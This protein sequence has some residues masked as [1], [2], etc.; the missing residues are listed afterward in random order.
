MG[1]GDG[2]NVLLPSHGYDDVVLERLSH[3]QD[4]VVLDRLPS[5][6]DVVLL[7]SMHYG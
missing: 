3:G 1:Y 6:D 2:V 4:N 7:M 5:H